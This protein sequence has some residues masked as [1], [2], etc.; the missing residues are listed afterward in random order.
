MSNVLRKGV[1]YSSSGEVVDCVFCRITSKHPDT[2]A[3][4][5]KENSKYVSF[6]PLRRATD[7]HLLISPKKHIST[8]QNLSSKLDAAMLREMIDFANYSLASIDPS[9]D[10]LAESASADV[11]YCFHVPP[12]NSIDHLH[13]HAIGNNSFS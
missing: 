6:V 12:Y 9:Y 1:T 7:F 13:L 3:T 2:P 10:Y 8:I 11:L 4:V 5:V